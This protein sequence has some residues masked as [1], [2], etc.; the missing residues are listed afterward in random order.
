MV[1]TL[2][3]IVLLSLVSLTGCSGEQLSSTGQNDAS[4]QQTLAEINAEPVPESVDLRVW[5]MLKAELVR[6]LQD[7]P[8]GSK[9]TATPPDDDNAPFLTFDPGGSTLNWGYYST[10]DY[11]QNGEVNVSD[12]TPLA[13]YYGQTGPFDPSAGAT[14]IRPLVT[15]ATIDPCV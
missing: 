5:S 3:F 1:R 6:L 14:S 13:I 10:G 4:L 2:A 9:Q 7:D 12:L 11:D 8:P 15:S